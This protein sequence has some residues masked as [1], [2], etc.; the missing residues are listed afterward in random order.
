VTGAL[1]KRPLGRS[2]LH[3]SPFCLGGNV[4]GWTADKPTSFALLDAF[5]GAG[6][7]FI[8]TADVYSAWLPGH[9]GGESETM[10]GDWLAARGGRDRVVIATKVGKWAPLPGLKAANIIA[11]CESSLK[12]LRTDHID[13]YQSHED[14][15]SVPQEESLAAFG[16][17]IAA[18]K[19]RAIGASNFSATRLAA[20]EKISEEGGLPRYDTL[21]PLYNLVDRDFERALQPLCVE[22]EIGVIPFY[23]LAAGFLTGK[24]RSKADAEGRARAGTVSKYLTPDNLALLDR[25][26]ALAKAR[27]VSL[28]Q[29][30]I[31]WLRDRPSV[32]A[33]IASATS[34]EQLQAL[35]EGASLILSPDE[36]A[37]LG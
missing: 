33:P 15:Q 29:I 32:V 34:L 19:V 14:D 28:A 8:D 20:A 31:A 17:L 27:H 7:D 16:K 36:I 25:M 26:E 4:F 37:A 10:I 12:R 1:Q 11:A 22:Q 24:Y 9:A 3:V 21:Q 18:G 2:G 35:I 23:A 13:L 5:T 30:A 6:F